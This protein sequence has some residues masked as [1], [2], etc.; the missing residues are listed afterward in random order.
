MVYHRS[1]FRCTY[2]F[3]LQAETR[4][5]WEMIIMEFFPLYFYPQKYMPLT[6]L[7]GSIVKVWIQMVGTG[8]ESDFDPKNELDFFEYNVLQ[9]CSYRGTYIR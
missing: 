7:T 8:S 6:K 9:Q 3:P 1:Q 2:V 5:P 4:G